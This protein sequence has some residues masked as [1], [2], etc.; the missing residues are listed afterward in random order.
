MKVHIILRSFWSIFLY[1]I[2][3][4]PSE[5]C[6]P[7]CQSN[8]QYLQGVQSH[9][10][11][12]SGIWSDIF[13]R[14]I[15]FSFKHNFLQ[16][17]YTCL[18]HPSLGSTLLTFLAPKM[19]TIFA[20]ICRNVERNFSFFSMTLFYSIWKISRNLCECQAI[21]SV[22]LSYDANLGTS[23]ILLAGNLDPLN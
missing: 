8:S 20:M 7:T 14:R 17:H 10:P 16:L 4:F 11:N 15:I 2:L 19:K 6:L 18:M 12:F 22:G 21:W 1:P 5:S 13:P 9:H 23:F 3:L